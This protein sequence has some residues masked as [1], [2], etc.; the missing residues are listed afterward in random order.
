MAKH[1][2]YLTSRGF[3]LVEA[4]IV[5]VVMSIAAL[6]IATMSGHIFDAET[7]NNTLE[8]GDQLMQGCAEQLLATRRATNGYSASSLASSAAATNSCSGMAFT[9][10]KGVT[11]SAPTVMITNG[12][13]TVSGMSACPYST[14]SNCRLVA[15]TQG[16]IKAI[17]FMLVN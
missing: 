5:M 16:G 17:N 2:A 4:I 12:N 1:P 13:S 6:G 11:Y 7:N 9:N 10:A 15:V 3:T 8:I 14:G